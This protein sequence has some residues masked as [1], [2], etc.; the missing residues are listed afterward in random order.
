MPCIHIWHYHLITL[1]HSLYYCATDL[2]GAM[3]ENL[4]KKILAPKGAIHAVLMASKSDD[5][6]TTTW[7]YNHFAGKFFGVYNDQD[8]KALTRKLRG[9][10]IFQKAQ[11]VSCT[12]QVRFFTD[13]FEKFMTVIGMIMLYP[14]V[15][16]YTLPPRREIT[17]YVYENFWIKQKP[18]IQ[19]QDHMVIY[20]GLGFRGI[21]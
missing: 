5:P 15:H 2:W 4:Y 12:D 19:M 11:V 17:E 9:N 3:F 14:E 21:I 10:P 8:L 6:M 16:K 20:R 1:H 7:L 18:L 13:D